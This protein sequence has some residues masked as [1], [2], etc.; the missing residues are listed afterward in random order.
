VLSLRLDN[1]T[2]IVQNG[3]VVPGA[4]E[5][6]VATI[7]FIA[8]GGDQ[9][10]FPAGSTTLGVSYQQALENYIVDGLGGVISAAEYPEGG[11]GRI[12]GQ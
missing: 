8:R 6:T 7:D 1:G 3:A 4:P 2:Y 12:V 9:Y 11:A 5:V 10:P